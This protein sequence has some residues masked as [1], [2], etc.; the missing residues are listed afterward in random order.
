MPNED[1]T[2]EVTLRV[3]TNPAT[4]D[5]LLT[6]VSLSV[7]ALTGALGTGLYLKKVNE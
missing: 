5:N 6:Y 4:G 3:A 2:V 7:V 1:V